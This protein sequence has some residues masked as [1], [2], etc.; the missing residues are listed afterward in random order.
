MVGVHRADPMA[1]KVEPSWG[2]QLE[3]Y[4]QNLMTPKPTPS[5]QPAITARFAF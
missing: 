4:S 3:R 2:S 1:R 5:I